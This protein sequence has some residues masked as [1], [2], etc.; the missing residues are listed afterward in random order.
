MLPFWYY[1]CGNIVLP[2]EKFGMWLLKELEERNMSQSDLARACSITTAQISRIISGTRSAGKESLTA[3]AHALRL[4]PDLVFEKAGVLPP[5]LEL[6]PI[7][8]N[9]LSRDHRSLSH[10]HRR[11]AGWQTIH[12]G[13]AT[14]PAI[15]PQP[16]HRQKRRQTIRRLHR[17]LPPTSR[18]STAPTRRRTAPF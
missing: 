17:L 9:D 15:L 1:L 8:R 5:K 16:S 11:S 4:P 14:H 6:S 10:P 18:R 13:N 7:K 2:M 12:R 3:I